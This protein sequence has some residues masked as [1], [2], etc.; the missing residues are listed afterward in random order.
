MQLPRGHGKVVSAMHP[1]VFA[2]L[3]VAVS[4]LGAAQAAALDGATLSRP[5]ALR[6]CIGLLATCCKASA[7]LEPA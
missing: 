3:A 6:Y 4:S 2:F 5:R 7:Q 1:H